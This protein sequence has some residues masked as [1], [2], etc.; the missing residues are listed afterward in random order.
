MTVVWK[1]NTSSELWAEMR[2]HWR[3]VR[4]AKSLERYLV[5]H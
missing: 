1:V 4:M 2:D 5:G 3:V